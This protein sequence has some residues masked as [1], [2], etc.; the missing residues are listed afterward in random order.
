MPFRERT[1]RR[2]RSILLLAAVLFALST[3]SAA[4]LAAQLSG[5]LPGGTGASLLFPYFEVALGDPSGLTTLLSINNAFNTEQLVRVVLWTDWAVPTLAFDLYLGPLSTQSLNLRDAFNGVL[6]STGQGVDLSAFDGCVADPPFHANPVLS[7]FERDVLSAAHTGFPHP[8]DFGCFGQSHGDSHARGYVTADVVSGCSGIEGLFPQA[9]PSESPYFDVGARLALPFNALWGDFFYVEPGENSAQ[10]EQAIALWSGLVQTPLPTSDTYTFYGRYLG[11]NGLDNRVPLPERWQVRFLNGGP[12]NGGTDLIVWRD[13]KALAEGGSGPRGCSGPPSWHPLREQ[14]VE[15][16][17]E[18]GNQVLSVTDSAFFPLATQKVA[19]SDLG[20]VTA[21]G[22]LR[23]GLSHGAGPYLPAQS[24]V[25][26][27]MTAS[28]L[29]SVSFAA[30]P[31]YDV[32][33]LDPD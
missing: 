9:A 25:M 3:L 6:P 2:R 1:P 23:L 29:Y 22:R 28:P 11:W 31:L 14:Y 13:T 30:S 17:D 24:W 26:P 32:C 8:L 5:C 20:I 18:A 33:G 21:F 4:P 7:G 12:F 15:A 10:G 19:V 16:Y 27:V